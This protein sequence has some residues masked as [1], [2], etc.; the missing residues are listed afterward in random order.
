VKTNQN[1]PGLLSASDAAWDPPLFG[2]RANDETEL[3]LRVPRARFVFVV[4]LPALFPLMSGAQPDGP[5]T[6]VANNPLRVRAGCHRA[7]PPY[8]RTGPG[9]ALDGKP[10]QHP[11]GMT[12]APIPNQALFESPAGW[13]SPTGGDGYNADPPPADG[14]K[15][16]ISDV[17]HV[18]P[19]GLIRPKASLPAKGG[20]GLA[21]DNSSSRLPPPRM[22]CCS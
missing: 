3:D 20:L 8:A 15:V 14:R 2:V 9:N 21:A 19:E 4:G 22:R 6:A 10:K 13:I 7:G 1:I 17:D 11:I 16:V 5:G 12:G 18:W